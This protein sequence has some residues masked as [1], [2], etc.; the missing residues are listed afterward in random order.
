MS[1]PKKYHYATVQKQVLRAPP[2]QPGMLTIQNL[3]ASLK[4]AEYLEQILSSR[5]LKVDVNFTN[6]GILEVQGEFDL[7]HLGKGVSYAS[8]QSDPDNNE[9]YEI[10]TVS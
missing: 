1:N 9:V 7:G 10:M 8:Y 3:F 4:D 5:G 6:W 2:D